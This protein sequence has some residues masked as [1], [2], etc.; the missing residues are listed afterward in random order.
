MITSSSSSSSRRC[1]RRRRRI[2]EQKKQ[3]KKKKY[4]SFD[5]FFFLLYFIRITDNKN[6]TYKKK[7]LQIL[8]QLRY[9]KSFLFFLFECLLLLLLF[10]V[11]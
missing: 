2:K 11:Y 6:I 10:D 9:N 7:K 1:R 8:Q 4:I 3:P 5:S